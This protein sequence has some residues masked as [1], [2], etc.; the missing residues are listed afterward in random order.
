M[1]NNVGKT[2]KGFSIAI[3]LIES[4]FSLIVGVMI[5]IEE[6]TT[7]GTIVMFGGIFIALVFTTLMY[8]L[9]TLVENSDNI[10]FKV[11]GIEKLL[12]ENNDICKKLN[13]ANI[14]KNDTSASSQNVSE[15]KKLIIN[16]NKLDAEEYLNY[17]RQKMNNTNIS[18]TEKTESFKVSTTDNKLINQSKD[19][20][21]NIYLRKN[22]SLFHLL[23]G[24]EIV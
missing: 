15:K 8:G 22:S 10:K 11:Y 1:Y 5:M 18:N 7:I 19:E 14:E 6:D 3:M 20:E 12:K 23:V 2:I 13:L 24:V 9:G 4:I 21:H 17:R 16:N